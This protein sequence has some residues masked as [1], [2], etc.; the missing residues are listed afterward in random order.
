MRVFAAR[1]ATFA[2]AWIPLHVRF[3][4]YEPTH[5][6]LERV[7]HRLQ[8]RTGS[9]CSSTNFLNRGVSA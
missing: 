7:S 6:L 4:G 5:I 9:I 8:L 2:L 1:D 3:M